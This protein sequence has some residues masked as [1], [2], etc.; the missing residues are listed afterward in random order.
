MKNLGQQNF[1]ESTD[2]FID[3]LLETSYANKFYLG[4]VTDF[5]VRKVS[6]LPLDRNKRFPTTVAI[7]LI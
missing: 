2:L 7:I 3:I 6:P 4:F 5:I 1:F